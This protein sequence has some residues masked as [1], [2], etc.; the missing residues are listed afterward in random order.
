[1]EQY[2]IEKELAKALFGKILLCTDN[3]TKEHVVIKRIQLDAARKQKAIRG[4]V[5][6]MEDAEMEKRA[7]RV[8]RDAGGHSHLLTMTKDFVENGHDHFVLEYCPRGELFQELETLPN[9]RLSHARALE[10]FDQITQAVV[11]LH[12]QGFAHGDLT[13]ENIFLDKHG[14][15]KIGDFG[16]AAE[17][18]ASKRHCAGKYFYMA[19][20][21]YLG[22]EYDPAKADVWSLGIMLFIMLTGTPLFDKATPSDAGFRFVKSKGFR[23]ICKEWDVD[24]LIPTDAMS[25]LEHMLQIQPN[26]RYTLSQV[27]DHP[28]LQTSSALEDKTALSS[29]LGRV[30]I[31]QTSQSARSA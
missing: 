3:N 27:R 9:N 21:M 30:S 6:V 18:K 13:L 1:M 7:Y 25:L 28:Y 2:T 15:C 4:G 5:K 31:S 11:F 10:C 22:M 20:E 24:H 8:V 23:L 29:M 19:P 17:M 12:A 16:L 14:D 26:D